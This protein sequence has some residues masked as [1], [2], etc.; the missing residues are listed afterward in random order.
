MEQEFWINSL[1]SNVEIFVHPV[2]GHLD[3]L[4]FVRYRLKS[5]WPGFD[6]RYAVQ[7]DVPCFSSFV[8]YVATPQE[9]EYSRHQ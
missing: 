7:V 5:R 4:R 2:G 3:W 9:K 6:L 1:K 8:P